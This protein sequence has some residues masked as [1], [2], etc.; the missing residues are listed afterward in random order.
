GLGTHP[1]TVRL[2][3][4]VLSLPDRPPTVVDADALNALGTDLASLREGGEATVLTPHP[5]EAGR[6]LGRTAAD[7]NADRIAAART[8][9]RTTG[10]GT[11][12][13]ERRA[14]GRRGD[15]VRVTRGDVGD[16]RAARGRRRR[17]R[18]RVARGPARRREDALREGA[19]RRARGGPFAGHEPDLHAREP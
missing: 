13:G 9:A 17:R 6:L 10:T 12:A 2:V 15:R 4:A 5:G 7:V 16:R 1:S 18:R 14:R 3:R 8:L 11:R 19:L